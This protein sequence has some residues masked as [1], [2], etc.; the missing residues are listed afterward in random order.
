MAEKVVQAMRDIG[1]EF[2]F[3][4]TLTRIEK[5]RDGKLKAFWKTAAELGN[6]EKSDIYDTVFLAV[7][8]SSY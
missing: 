6:I 8:K 4:S 1:V 7:G 3:N 5:L 2:H